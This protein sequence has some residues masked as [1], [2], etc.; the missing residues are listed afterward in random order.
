M[1]RQQDLAVRRAAEERARA[2]ERRAL[3]ERKQ[4]WVD[5]LYEAQQNLAVFSE[6]KLVDPSIFDGGADFK[7]ACDELKA[8]GIYVELNHGN[9][10]CIAMWTGINGRKHMKWFHNHMGYN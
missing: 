6:D 5:K 4:S 9:E 10:Q 3:L 8:K 2:E 7:T 1:Q